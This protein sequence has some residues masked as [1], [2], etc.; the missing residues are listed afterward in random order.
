MR[1]EIVTP[2]RAGSTVG[3]RITAERWARILT[4][5]GH[6]VSLSQKTD[7]RSPDM[8]IALHARRSHSSI[9]R[10]R[11]Q[12]PNKPIVLALTGTDVY[13]DIHQNGRARKSLD[14]A[15][16][17]LVLQP[18]A[19]RQLTAAEQ[20]KSCVIYQ[21]VGPLRHMKEPR[22]ES[23]GYHFDVCVMG[24]LRAVK[25]PFR[26]A[27]A[28]R[29]LPNSSRVR[30]TQVGKALSKDMERRAL[31]EMQINQRYRWLGEVS[32]AR[33]LGVM[34]RSRLYVISSR[35]EGGA[36]ALAEAIGAGVPILS[37]R[38]G[39]NLGILGEKYPGFFRRGDTNALRNLIARA[40]TDSQFL[41]DLN[42]RIKGLAPLFNPVR[43]KQAW[44][45]L[46]AELSSRVSP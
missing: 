30:I 15:D 42:N 11:H 6:R 22:R 34:A 36:N 35:M 46:L 44:A 12:H 41:S 8:L 40:E 18:D 26:A 45:C 38:I 9:L 19:L 24:H 21:S 32:H 29:R 4:D 5:L 17:L 23:D 13:R 31:R 16:R 25:D 2:A 43:E 28:A 7:K 39:G 27:M 1:I 10:F 20:E 37:S 3:N 33:A 14:L